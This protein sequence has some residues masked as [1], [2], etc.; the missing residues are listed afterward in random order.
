MQRLFAGL[1]VFLFGCQAEQP[2]PPGPDPKANVDYSATPSTHPAAKKAPARLA[3]NT[4]EVSPNDL[5]TLDFIRLERGPCFGRCP[6][7]QATMLSTGE[8]QLREPHQTVQ[9]SQRSAQEF[10]KLARLLEQANAL[11]FDR[12]YDPSNKRLCPNYSTDHPSTS[13]LFRINGKNHA[14]AHYHGCVGFQDEAALL[15]LETD[16]QQAM[17]LPLANDQ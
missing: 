16:L 7:F 17:Q 10:L 13:I 14:I 12:H 2:V 11:R 6:V 15:K 5:P 4:E 8:L 9:I 3:D 1:L